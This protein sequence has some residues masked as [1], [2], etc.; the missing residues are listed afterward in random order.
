M[1]MTQNQ[2]VYETL[3]KLIGTGVFK[4]G[5]KIN[6]LAIA[7]EY[8]VSRAPVRE[9]LNRIRAKKLVEYQVNVGWRVIDI[10]LERVVEFYEL[11]ETLEAQAT[12][13]ACQRIN[14]QELV[15]LEKVLDFHKEAITQD[16]GQLYFEQVADHDFHHRIL[17][18][19]R[20]SFLIELLNDELY[21]LMQFYRS[22]LRVSAR[23]E[24]ALEEHRTIFLAMKANHPDQAAELMRDHI[25]NVSKD[26]VAFNSNEQLKK[27]ATL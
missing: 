14:R 25:R 18:A 3:L 11:R 6:E 24:T 16:N 10:D 23:F 26:I 17:L 22:N 27:G 12:A 7:R 8:K 20:N 5:Q 4:P 15:D 1:T 13:L 9:A 21:S 19:S 2:L